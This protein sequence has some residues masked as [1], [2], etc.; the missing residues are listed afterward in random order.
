MDSPNATQ[1]ISAGM[2]TVSTR[3]AVVPSPVRWPSWKTHTKAPNAALS[4]SMFIT[5]P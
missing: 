1:K 2:L 4:D 5:R 3:V